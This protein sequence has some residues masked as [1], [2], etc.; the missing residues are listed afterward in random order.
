MELEE[1]GA[2]LIGEAGAEIFYPE[3]EPNKKYLEPE[4]RKNGSAPQHWQ[5]LGLKKSFGTGTEICLNLQFYLVRYVS[6]LMPAKLLHLCSCN[7]F[8]TL[9]YEQ[10]SNP[11]PDPEALHCFVSSARQ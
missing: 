10:G 8:S 4:P 5:V 1:V 9:N 3:P 6:C 2:E 7:F 11:D